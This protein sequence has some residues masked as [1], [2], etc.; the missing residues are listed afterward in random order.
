M[1]TTVFCSYYYYTS[2]VFVALNVQDNF[3]LLQY[4]NDRLTYGSQS[5]ST[6]RRDTLGVAT[7][8]PGRNDTASAENTGWAY[9]SDLVVGSR[10]VSTRGPINVPCFQSGKAFLPGTKF[11]LTLEHRFLILK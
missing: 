3:P 5:N 7:D 11:S 6:W 1:S 4:V 9:R 10:T 8:S 2:V